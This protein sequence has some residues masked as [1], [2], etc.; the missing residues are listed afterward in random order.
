MDAFNKFWDDKMLEYQQEAEKLE[1]E[2]L[3]RHQSEI[4]EYES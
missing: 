3:D 2:A 1:D 4:E